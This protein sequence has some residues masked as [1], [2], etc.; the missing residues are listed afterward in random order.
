MS[1]ARRLWLVRAAHSAIYLVMVGCIVAILCAGITG[2]HGPWLPAAVALVSLESLVFAASGWKC[3]LTALA[4]R[5][6]A[7]Q[8][9]LFDTFLPERITRHTF[10]VCGPLVVLGLLMLAARSL[11]FGWPDLP[12][13]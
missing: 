7:G 5:Y 10:Q 11:W 13:P 6:G 12:A 2:V 4:V 1:D 8:G 3:P 9:P